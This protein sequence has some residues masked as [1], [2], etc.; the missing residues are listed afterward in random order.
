MQL[1]KL[2]SINSLLIY[3]SWQSIMLTFGNRKAEPPSAWSCIET[4]YLWKV[5]SD[6]PLC[7]E[8]QW[9]VCCTSR[10]N[11]YMGAGV[12]LLWSDSFTDHPSPFPLLCP[13]LKSWH[14]SPYVSCPT[15]FPLTASLARH[16]WRIRKLTGCPQPLQPCSVIS[17]SLELETIKCCNGLFSR[18]WIPTP[19]A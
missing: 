19:G 1:R 14:A 10:H 3:R 8:G 4:N 11:L 16:L 7:W 9:Q 2:G 18:G 5:T 12:K 13:L 15:S 6:I 17:P